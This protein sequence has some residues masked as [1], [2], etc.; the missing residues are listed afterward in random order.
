[1]V[2]IGNPL[3]PHEHTHVFLGE[4]HEQN[5]RKTW[6]VIALCGVMMVVEIVAPLVQLNRMKPLPLV[7]RLKPA[8]PRTWGSSAASVMPRPRHS[9]RKQYRVYEQPP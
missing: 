8:R 6:A 2:H 3:G 1:M 5:E 4:G 7:Q 9:Q